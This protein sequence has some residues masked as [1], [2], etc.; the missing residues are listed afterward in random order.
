MYNT[1]NQA[2]RLPRVPKPLPLS[3][4]FTGGHQI[5]HSRIEHCSFC[6]KLKVCRHLLYR[7]LVPCITYLYCI[8][9]SEFFN[10]PSAGRHPDQHHRVHGEDRAVPP[11]VCASEGA[12]IGLPPGHQGPLPAGPGLRWV[13]WSRLGRHEAER[14]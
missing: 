7:H 6:Y 5:L 8:I 13:T 4:R 9:N 2:D 3:E 12:H 10:I 1:E 14:G 11:P